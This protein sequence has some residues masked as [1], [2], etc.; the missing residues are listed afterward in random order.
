M[1]ADGRATRPV[2]EPEQERSTWAEQ[3]NAE[4]PL[5]MLLLVGRMIE[6]LLPHQFSYR[7]MLSQQR[8]LIPTR[9]ST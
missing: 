2:T 8:P 4:H 3:L 7:A 1:Q 9:S 6:V 5:D